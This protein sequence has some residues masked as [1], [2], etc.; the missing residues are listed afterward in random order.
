MKLMFLNSPGRKTASTISINGMH[1]NFKKR[2]EGIQFF[3]LTQLHQRA[4]D[5]ESQ[6][7]DTAKMVRHNIH[8]SI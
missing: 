3:E 6:S 1:Y 2:L 5:C 7:K 8:E 4:L